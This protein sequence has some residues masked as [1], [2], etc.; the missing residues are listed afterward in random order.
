[1]GWSGTGEVTQLAPVG[2]LA[3][4]NPVASMGG[5]AG[6]SPQV[7]KWEAKVTFALCPYSWH[8]S[9]G[10]QPC[11]SL[12]TQSSPGPRLTG[13]LVFDEE[14]L[15]SL[16]AGVLVDIEFH[17]DPEGG[18]EAEAWAQGVQAQGRGWSLKPEPEP[19]AQLGSFKPQEQRGTWEETN[20]PTLAHPGLCLK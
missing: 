5:G 15:E 4:F 20:V 2:S 14:Q 17:L 13:S 19:Q 8:S 6:M 18:E 7:K 1:M 3:P 10:S 12:S 9:S 16:F 11:P